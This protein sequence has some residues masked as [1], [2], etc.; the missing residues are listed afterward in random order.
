MANSLTDGNWGSSGDYPLRDDRPMGTEPNNPGRHDNQPS[1][2]GYAGPSVQP[3]FGF[4]AYMNHRMNASGGQLI[5]HKNAGLS[6][7]KG[8][9][10]GQTPGQ[11]QEA[12]R[13]EYEAL[14]DA[15]RANW[16][17]NARGDD[18]RS[19]R[20]MPPQNSPQGAPNQ[21]PSAAPQPPYTA[22]G[23]NP[24]APPAPVDQSPRPLAPP[25]PQPT[26][27]TPVAAPSP[28]GRPIAPPTGTPAP[29]PPAPAPALANSFPQAVAPAP[30]AHIGG[31]ADDT[32]RYGPKLSGGGANPVI[33]TSGTYPNSNPSFPSSLAPKTPD[34][35]VT[36]TGLPGSTSTTDS[37]YKGTTFNDYSTPAPTN[38][39]SP[40]QKALIGQVSPPSTPL[41]GL[42][43][44]QS[45]FLS[46][47][48]VPQ[49]AQPISS[50]Q[51]SVPIIRGNGPAPMPSAGGGIAPSDTSGSRPIAS[52]PP[53]KTNAT[54]ADIDPATGKP[55]NSGMNIA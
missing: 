42:N 26:P 1:T 28:D 37:N 41:E 31:D 47:H 52:Q 11:A 6:Y 46:D 2:R 13:A 23:A 4:E 55:R 21:A 7:D 12:I 34:G 30:P 8:D 24:T 27:P 32:A 29:V 35:S 19:S 38:A 53:F 40:I 22:S 17:S 39:S 43:P 25:A 45:S 5:G 9:F 3:K 48:G 18:V 49:P 15:Q 54:G 44:G 33:S 36:V 50:V 51:S 20:E 10:R 16:E 14:P